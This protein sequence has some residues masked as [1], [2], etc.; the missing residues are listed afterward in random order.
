VELEE[1]QENPF[2]GSRELKDDN[3]C[4]DLPPNHHLS[5]LEFLISKM[6]IVIVAWRAL[7]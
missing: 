2:A 4:D 3:Y 5:K 6:G 1:G 7:L